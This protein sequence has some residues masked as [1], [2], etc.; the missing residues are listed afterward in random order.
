M[1]ARKILDILPPEKIKKEKKEVF[2]PEKKKPPL[3]EIP[4]FN[5]K[6]YS[7]LVPILILIGIFS[8]F[9]LPK[10]EIDIWPETEVRSIEIEVVLDKNVKTTDFINKIIPGQI[11]ETQKTIVSEFSSSGKVLEEKKAEGMIRVYNGYSTSPQVFRVQTRLVSADGKLFRSADRVSIPGGHYEEGKFVPGFVD[12]EVMADQAGEEF[13]I[14]ASTFSIPGLVGTPLYTYFYGKSFQPMTGGFSKEVSQV[15]EEDLERA[16]MTVIEE[17]ES[18]SVTALNEKVPL[19]FVLPKDTIE[20]EILEF[21]S[22]EAETRIDRFTV[23]VIVKSTALIFKLKDLE[24]LATQLILLE[25]PEDKKL[26][27]EGLQVNYSAQI[28]DLGSGEITLNLAA[29]AKIYSDI[30]IASLEG[31]LKGRMLAEAQLFL[32]NYPEINKAFVK[33]WP[34][35]V[36]KVPQN[37]EKIEIRFLVD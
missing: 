17:A 21:S 22:V 36:K 19:T 34:F 13:N 8:Y 33:F 14:G 35:W 16:E 31:A 27:R 9:T 25:V 32:E 1:M 6:R 30:D 37:E 7:I 26:Y 11:I 12:I 2:L 18:E 20:T 23:K 28:I 24:D 5:L 3:P 29:E 4:S 15:T 10:A